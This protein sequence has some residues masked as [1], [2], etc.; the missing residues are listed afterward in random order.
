M[1]PAALSAAQTASDVCQAFE[2]CYTLQDVDDFVAI[3]STMCTDE[4]VALKN[5]QMMDYFGTS[6]RAQLLFIR[7]IASRLKSGQKE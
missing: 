1:I 4:E 3:Y 6:E 7:W 5:L 2:M